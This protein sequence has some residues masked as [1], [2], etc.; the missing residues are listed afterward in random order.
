MHERLPAAARFGFG[1]SVAG[2]AVRV[3]R[4]TPMGF[5]QTD[6]DG[7]RSSA[8]GAGRL[9][10]D[11]EALGQEPAAGDI[12]LPLGEGALVDAPEPRE[13]DG[14]VVPDRQTHVSAM[15]G[16]EN[17]AMDRTHR[18]D[19]DAPGNYGIGTTTTDHLPIAQVREGMTVVDAAG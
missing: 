19:M 7:T 4:R 14:G 9:T 3:E 5:D 15:A 16:A 8:S 1:S 10:A 17:T 6:L 11:D 13:L 12:N 18:Q 2:A